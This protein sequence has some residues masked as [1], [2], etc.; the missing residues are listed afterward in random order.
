MSLASPDA[1]R[2]A[3]AYP[4]TDHRFPRSARHGLDGGFDPSWWAI[5][6]LVALRLAEKPWLPRWGS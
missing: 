1:S 3:G 4:N 5:R 6:A 2:P